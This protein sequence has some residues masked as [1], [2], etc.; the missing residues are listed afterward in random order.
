MTCFRW[1]EKSTVEPVVNRSH[2]SDSLLVVCVCRAVSHGG[3]DFCCKDSAT[4]GR[5]E[6]DTPRG[7]ETY[8]SSKR[9]SESDAI[10]PCLA[11][12]VTA[13]VRYWRG[14]LANYIDSL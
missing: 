14:V 12:S 5:R 11:D 2:W 9:P 8:R 10:C 6:N 3:S 13:R 4:E 1:R 7:H